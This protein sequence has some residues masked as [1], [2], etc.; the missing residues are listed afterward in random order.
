MLLINN[1]QCEEASPIK[2]CIEYIKTNYADNAATGRYPVSDDGTYVMIQEYETKSP[3]LCDWEA[4]KKYVDF[5]FILSGCERV[6]VSALSQMKQGEYDEKID[7]TICFG[8]PM[9]T[10]TLSEG[11][12]IVLMP[13]DVH[14]PCLSI[15]GESTH[16]RKAV[17][18][19][20]VE[21]FN[22]F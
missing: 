16:I 14:M 7:F 10:I 2:K 3:D 4:H 9:Q 18:K 22:T 11:N 12:G 21:C 1:M 6:G 20:P 5:Q 15:D 17:F 8:E 19:I 13:E